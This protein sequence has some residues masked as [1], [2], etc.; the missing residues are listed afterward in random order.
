[1][2]PAIA[3]PIQALFLA[4]V[5]VVHVEE[6]AYDLP[7]ARVYRQGRYSRVVESGIYVTDAAIAEDVRLCLKKTTKCGQKNTAL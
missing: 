1:M 3:P 6:I 5:A 7:C 4:T 2:I